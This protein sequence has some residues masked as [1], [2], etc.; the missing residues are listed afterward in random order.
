[1]DAEVFSNILNV[2]VIA[3]I[4]VFVACLGLF[5]YSSLKEKRAASR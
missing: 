1:M 2:L 5:G 3:T 4:V